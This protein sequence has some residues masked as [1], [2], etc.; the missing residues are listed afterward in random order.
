MSNGNN[1]SW[2]LKDQNGLIISSGIGNFGFQDSSEFY[3]NSEIT[4][5][6]SL[7]D[8]KQSVKI[9]PNPT[10]N[11]ATIEILNSQS[12][13]VDISIF[14]LR[15]NLIFMDKDIRSSS[16]LIKNTAWSK[17]T[18]IVKIKMNDEIIHELIVIN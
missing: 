12:L 15:G 14:D 3:I 13:I 1:G 11:K 4:S 16:Y 18:Y 9:F 2:E 5:N 17:G 8:K 10:N 6:S 7:I